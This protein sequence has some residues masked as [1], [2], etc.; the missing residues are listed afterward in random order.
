MSANAIGGTATGDRRRDA[1]RLDRLAK[2]LA[3]AIRRQG[4]DVEPPQDPELGE[5]L[6]VL[7]QIGVEPGAFFAEVWPLPAVVPDSGG[8]ETPRDPGEAGER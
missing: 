1:G 8:S 4:A 3:A 2:Y 5:V 7:D 6:E